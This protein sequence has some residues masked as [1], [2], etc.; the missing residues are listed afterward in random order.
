MMKEILNGLV[1]APLKWRRLR[2]HLAFHIRQRHYDLLQVRVPLSAGLAAPV[3]SDEAW[4]SFSEIFLQEEYEQVFRLLPL[5]DRWIDLGCHAGFFSL[6]VE[7]RRRLDGREGRPQ[8]LLVDADSRSARAIERVI[9]LNRL[10]G[11]MTFQHGAVSAGTGAVQFSQRAFMA[12]GIAAVDDHPGEPSSVPIITPGR[13][14]ELLS[15]PYD[16][17]KVDIEGSEHDFIDHYEPVWNR[18]RHLVL[19]CHDSP[20]TGNSWEDGA[21]RIVRSTGF[22]RLRLEGR[23]D[24]PERPAGLLLLRNPAFQGQ[25]AAAAAGL[26]QA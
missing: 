25:P 5:P 22:E 24:E 21:G 9:A 10:E 14:V 1:L 4:V 12:S 7:Q 16:L 6:F 18:A 26:R 20:S 13:I 23:Q 3:L 8:A 17:V 11:Q 15:P 19:E 2:E